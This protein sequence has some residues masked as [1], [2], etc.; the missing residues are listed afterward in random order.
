MAL[1]IIYNVIVTII[2]LNLLV[3][4]MN[5]AM[6]EVVENRVSSWKYHRTCVWMDY[7]GKSVVMPSPVNLF[8]ILLDIMVCFVYSPCHLCG[9]VENETELIRRWKTMKK[10][11]YLDLIKGLKMRYVQHNC[12]HELCNGF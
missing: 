12:R 4:M 7:C 6:N 3:A 5:V 10:M 9:C 11:K 2:L 1:W 8:I